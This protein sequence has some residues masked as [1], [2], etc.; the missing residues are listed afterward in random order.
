M[1]GTSTRYA[2]APAPNRPALAVRVGFSGHRS[3][4]RL[5][6]EAML[7]ANLDAAF[8]LVARSVR[9]VETTGLEHLGETVGDTFAAPARLQLVTGVAP[10]A[11]REAIG[12]WRARRLGRIHALTPY[13]DP[14]TGGPLTDAPGDA[15]A[16]D[17]VTDLAGF[18]GWTCLDARAHG[19]H[20]HAELARWIVR[21]SEVVVAVWDG[22]SPTAPGGAATLVR[23]ALAKGLPVLWIA[24][25]L[26]GVRL[27]GAVH[28]WRDDGVVEAMEDPAG[29]A[30]PATA[31]ALCA[32]LF[33][34][35]APPAHVSAR[36]EPETR[37]LDPETIARRDYTR[38]NPNPAADGWGARASR[39]CDRT[40]W[41][42][43]NLF[44]QWLG[45]PA[46]ASPAQTSVLLGEASGQP[47]FAALNLAFTQADDRADRLSNAHRSQQLILLVLALLV[48]FVGVLPVSTAR[49]DLHLL[50][51]CVEL[52][53]AVFIYWLWSTA[54]RGHRHRRWS[55]ARR[56]AER[57]RAARATF[58]LGFDVADQHAGPA[59]TWT[60]WRAR[61]VIRDAGVSGGVLNADEVERR[62]AWAKAE[63]ID[64]QLRYHRREAVTVGRIARRLHLFENLIFAALIVGVL[65]GGAAA[66]RMWLN[67]PADV[68]LQ[69]V[70]ELIMRL[71]TMVS[72]LA[73][74]AGAGVLALDATNG[75]SE[76]AER[77]AQLAPAFEE[78]EVRVTA[79]AASSLERAQEVLRDAATLLVS[80]A[81]SWRE[82]LV[83]RRLVRGG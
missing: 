48:V 63:V 39:L 9:E 28:I 5:G 34:T 80:D 38:W 70:L 21:H 20:G 35:L 47:G 82:R 37:R 71:S 13:L 6:D 78:F 3:L 73:P 4:E 41:L 83:R 60:E 79:D 59:Q 65:C 17:H 75:F 53:L 19:R 49:P 74:A 14:R 10:G 36:R 50:A 1:G 67:K 8:D 81:D 31:P 69:S 51:I 42:S 45:G 27:L 64:G 11:D 32:L 77:S 2:A 66:A 55:D 18:E 16:D 43:F 25:G 22:L 46:P 56:L 58:P 52:V 40:L 30:S 26:E 76:L 57:L 33:H 54:R 62:V 15:R 68:H 7:H 12:R 61:A 72:A 44:K 23:L 24:P 29:H